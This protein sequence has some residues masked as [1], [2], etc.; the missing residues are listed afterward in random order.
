MQVGYWDC[1]QGHSDD[2]LVIFVISD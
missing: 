2:N 1:L